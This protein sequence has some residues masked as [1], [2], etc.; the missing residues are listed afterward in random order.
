MFLDRFEVS[1]PQA[2]TARQGVFEGVWAEERDGGGLGPLRP[3][4]HPE[5]RP[6]ARS[7][8]IRREV[9]DWLPD[10]RPARFV[11]RRRRGIG[12]LVVSPEGLLTPRIGRVPLVDAQG[13]DEPGGL[14]GDRAP[15]VPGGGGTA[16]RAASEPGAR[17][18]GGVV[19]GD[20]VGVRARSALGGG[21]QGVPLVRLPLVAASLAAVRASSRG[22]DVRP[23]AVRGRRRGRRRLPALWAK[24][25]YLWTASDPALAA[26]N[27][28][29]L[30]P[31]LAIGRLPATTRGAGGGA[32]REASGVGGLGPGP[33]GQGGSR[34]GQP[35]PRG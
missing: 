8:R 19:R 7:R 10:A 30:L 14:P 28:E 12:T 17:L 21:D 35:G 2:P 6:S 11:S 31:D 5:G 15:G 29:D 3:S 34:G 25:S 20:R 23:A 22:R 24:T 16:S 26:V 4:C 9:G 27:G 18:A 32:G 1:Y 33:C 13:G